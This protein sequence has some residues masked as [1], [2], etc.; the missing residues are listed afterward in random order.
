MTQR[1]TDND[2]RVLRAVEVACGEFDGFAPHGARD[3]VAV[4]RLRASGLVVQNAD[5]RCETCPEGHDTLLYVLTSAG[6]AALESLS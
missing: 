5:G 1:L 4:R 2:S 6:E 3:W